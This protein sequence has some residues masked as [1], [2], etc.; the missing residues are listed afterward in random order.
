MT[1]PI[2]KHLEL[3][4]K[5]LVALAAKARK[6]SPLSNLGVDVKR[7]GKV[8]YT[9]TRWSSPKILREVKH[10]KAHA[11]ALAALEEAILAEIPAGEWTLVAWAN[12]VER[13][14]ELGRH[15]HVRA[16]TDLPDNEWAAVY[17][18]QAD[19]GKLCFDGLTVET[20]TGLL[21]VFPADLE[22]WIPFYDMPQPR[23]SIAFNVRP[24]VE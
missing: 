18:A 3:D 20:T 12:H 4:N 6:D 7:D 13:G 23:V 11:A 19:G 22:H 8:I 1:Y 2:Q 10:A 17:Y 5:A 9:G 15:N 16:G 24:V 21:V 14:D